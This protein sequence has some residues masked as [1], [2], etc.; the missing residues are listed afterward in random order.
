MLFAEDKI[1]EYFCPPGDSNVHCIW[2]C[3]VSR[4]KIKPEAKQI[5][6]DYMNLSWSISLCEKKDDNWHTLNIRVVQQVWIDSIQKFDQAWQ[7][8]LKEVCWKLKPFTT[9]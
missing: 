3:I 8:G 5:R 6:N 1:L 9:F 7:C 2:S 4:V